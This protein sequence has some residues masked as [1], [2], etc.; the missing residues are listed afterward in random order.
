MGKSYAR[1]EKKEARQNVL[2]FVFQPESRV[3]VRADRVQMESSERVKMLGKQKPRA[4]CVNACERSA[5]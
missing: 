2:P 1:A 5:L 4:C 3:V